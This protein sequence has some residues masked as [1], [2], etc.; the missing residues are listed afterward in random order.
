M[1]DPLPIAGSAIGIV[2]LGIT[3][4]KG[5]I[6][7]YDG[8]RGKSSDVLFTTHRIGRLLKVL[9]ALDKQTLDTQPASYASQDLDLGI[10]GD[11]V[12]DAKELIEDPKNELDNFSSTKHAG[13]HFELRAIGRRLIY[14]LRRST[15][16]K[17]DEKIDTLIKD[18]SFAP[19]LLEKGDTD[20]ILGDLGDTK[21]L[22]HLT[23]ASQI[24]QTLIVWLKAPD[25]SIDFNEAGQETPQHR[26][27]A[28]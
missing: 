1:S 24:S 17:L 5:L 19:R 14:P 20:K 4:A 3:V 27:L 23:R 26:K 9:Q 16:Q 12:E 22:L 21:A 2:S 25:A 8:F 15:P 28:Y 18:L 10:I 7:Y 6:D 13:A 11:Y